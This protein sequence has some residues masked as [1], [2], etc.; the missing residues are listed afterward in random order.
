MS[1]YD[2]VRVELK[3]KEILFEGQDLD[4]QGIFFRFSPLS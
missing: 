1:N 4:R 2:S 3:P